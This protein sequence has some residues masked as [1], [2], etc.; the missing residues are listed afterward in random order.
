M[1][2]GDRYTTAST[3]WF[4]KGFFKDG[5]MVFENFILLTLMICSTAL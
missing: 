5:L 4:S 3:S 1:I 2:A